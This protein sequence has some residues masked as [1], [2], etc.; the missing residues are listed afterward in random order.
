MAVGDNQD[1]YNRLINNLPGWFGGGPDSSGKNSNHP[2]LDQLLQIFITT[3]YFHYNQQ[4]LYA[5]LQQRIQSATDINLDLISQDYMGIYLPRFP[6]ENDDTYRQRILANVVKEKATRP[7]MFNA[8]LILTGFPPII[9]EPWS[10][11]DNGGY[12]IPVGGYSYFDSMGIQHRYGIFLYGSMSSATFPY[13]FEIVVFLHANQGLAQFPGYQVYPAVIASGASYYGYNY[14][15]WWWG[16]NSLV[17]QIITNNI[18]LQTIELTK[19]LG[20]N[21]RKLTVNFINV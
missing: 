17:T 10:A 6:K 19:T 18:I 9:Y 14:N 2:N 15:N 16:S 13:Q 8:L 20:T 11:F 4:Y 12:N 1:I 5:V 3:Y 21:L 7:G